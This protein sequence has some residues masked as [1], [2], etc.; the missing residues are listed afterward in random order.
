MRPVHMNARRDDRRRPEVKPGSVARS[1]PRPGKRPGSRPA[2]ARG[3]A[4]QDPRL[5]GLRWVPVPLAVLAA[6]VGW[7]IVGSLQGQFAAANAH[8]QPAYQE[9]G[10]GMGV[11]QMLWMS[12]DMTGQGPLKVS[13]GYSMDPSMM[14]D[15]Q[16]ANNNRLRVEV[17][18]R[19]VTSDV[20]RYSMGDFTVVTTGGQSVKV[21]GNG[22][23]DTATSGLLEPGFEVTLDMYFDIPVAKSKNLTVKWS[24]D[25]STVSIPVNTSGALPGKMRM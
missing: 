5:P 1:R 18:I 3:R 25:G 9:G 6:V 21:N 20:Q 15:M 12:N 16:T 19:N 10:L 7:L 8:N 13:K 24:R 17:N 14:P 11:S 22:R 4:G 23:S 2:R